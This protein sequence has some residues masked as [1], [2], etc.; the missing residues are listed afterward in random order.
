MTMRRAPGSGSSRTTSFRLTRPTG[1]AQP[2]SVAR[3]RSSSSSLADKPKAPA[4]LRSVPRA[5]RGQPGFCARMIAA[6]AC[7]WTRCIS[8]TSIALRPASAS[9]CSKSWR[10]SAQRCIRS[11]GACQHR[12]AES[13]SG[14]AITSEIASR[15]PPR[16]TRATS[17]STVSLSAER[18]S[19]Q[20]EITTSMLAS[21]SVS[22]RCSPCETRHWRLPPAS[23][24]G[25][26]G[27][28]SRRSCPSRS[29]CRSD[30]L[31]ARR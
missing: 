27:R 20:F 17:R 2:A 9:V 30:R 22:P 26:R 19:T 13:M 4:T 28:A 25:G 23:H 16:S 1:T 7:W 21:G 24:C 29:P 14:S 18:F 6:D 15:P 3:S 5:R 10:V 12:V 11:T 31:D 8:R